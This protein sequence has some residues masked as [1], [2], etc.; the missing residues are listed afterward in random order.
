MA[1][2]PYTST[3]EY[4]VRPDLTSPDP[5]PHPYRPRDPVI[6]ELHDQL[7]QQFPDPQGPS[8]DPTFPEPVTTEAQSQYTYDQ[9]PERPTLHRKRS[10]LKRSNS[11]SSMKSVAWAMDMD[12]QKSRYEF[13]VEEIEVAGMV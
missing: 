8:P 13:A 1:G 7:V 4:S 9:Q 11:R 12:Q 6:G 10:S 5:L 3:V 2:P